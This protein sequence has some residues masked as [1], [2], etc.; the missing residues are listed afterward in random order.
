REMRNGRFPLAAASLGKGVIRVAM[1][2]ENQLT[3][4]LAGLKIVDLTAVLMG[5]STTQMLAELGADVVKIESPEGDATRKIGPNGD[6]LMGPIY[7]GLNRNKRSLVLD[8]KSAR[9]REAF[10]RLA[11]DADVVVTNVRPKGMERLRLTY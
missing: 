7:L 5:P 2:K 10:L 11:A 8:L 4:P 1:L 9:G 3:G 6:A